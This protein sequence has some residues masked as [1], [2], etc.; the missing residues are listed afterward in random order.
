MAAGDDERRGERSAIPRA[1]AGLGLRGPVCVDRRYDRGAKV[2]L[3]AAAGVSNAWL[4]NPQSHT[5]EVLRLSSE[6]PSEWTSLS[7]FTEDAKVRAEPFEAF[8]LDLS[9]L[10]QDVKL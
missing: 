8:E 5:L 7:V 9:I 1:S 10:W 6:R 2:R 3:Y 4:V